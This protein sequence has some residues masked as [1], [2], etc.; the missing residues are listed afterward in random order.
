[1]KKSLVIIFWIVG[2]ILVGLASKNLLF[3]LPQIDARISD[4]QER[5]DVYSS[6]VIT[7][8]LNQGLIST[9]S[10]ELNLLKTFGLNETNEQYAEIG[11]SLRGSKVDALAVL[12]QMKTGTLPTKEEYDKWMR[13][14]DKDLAEEQAKLLESFV[15]GISSGDTQFDNIVKERTDL[16][17]KKQRTTRWIVLLQVAGLFLTQLGTI[18]ELKFRTKV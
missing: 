4:N 15:G 3:D 16:S 9:L 1:M 12:K 7:F 18:L 14:S 8:K 6:N 2:T 13:I 17:V 11:R 10:G 5:F